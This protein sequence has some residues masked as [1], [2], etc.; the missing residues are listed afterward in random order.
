MISL[1]SSTGRRRR[2]GGACAAVALALRD[3]FLLLGDGNALHDVV[4]FAFF[5]VI[6]VDVDADDL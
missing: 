3:F 5:V 4:G 2:N 1:C 6:F